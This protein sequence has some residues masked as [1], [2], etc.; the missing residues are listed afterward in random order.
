MVHR[1]HVDMIL[2]LIPTGSPLGQYLG[3]P[4]MGLHAV[5]IHRGTPSALDAG[6]PIWHHGGASPAA[7]TVV[8]LDP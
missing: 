2:L 3:C 1:P 6:S 5:Q 4:G 7:C 8:V